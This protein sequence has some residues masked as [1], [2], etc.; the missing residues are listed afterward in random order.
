M[1]SSYTDLEPKPRRRALVG[2]VSLL[3]LAAA[4]LRR[5]G[6]TVPRAA[7]AAA[8]ALHTAVQNTTDAEAP[9][10]RWD[11]ELKVGDDAVQ[12]NWPN[13]I[14]ADDDDDKWDW[15][16]PHSVMHCVSGDSYTCLSY[17]HEESLWNVCSDTCNVTDENLVS[18]SEEKAALYGGKWSAYANP[19]MKGHSWLVPCAWEG[20][21]DLPRLCNDTFTPYLPIGAFERTSTASGG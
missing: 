19:H 3:A 5:S 9:T 15:G 10:E 6:A 1:R 7:R 17:T 18:E 12:K 20:I 11:D 21:A 4:A 13:L 14:C 8:A 16:A 2:A